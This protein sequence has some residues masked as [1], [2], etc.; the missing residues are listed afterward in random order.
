MAWSGELGW[1]VRAPEP[2]QFDEV[3]VVEAEPEPTDD[4]HAGHDHGPGGH[5]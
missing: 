5:H 3:A 1:G 4:A 2:A